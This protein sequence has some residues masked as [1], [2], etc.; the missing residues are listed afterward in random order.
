MSPANSSNTAVQESAMRAVWEQHRGGILAKVGLI[1]QAVSALGTDR[2]DDELR[3]EAQRSA[4]MLSG[5]LG[6]FGFNRASEAARELELEFAGA[7]SARTTT[8]STL[9]AIVRRGLDWE[10]SISKADAARQSAEEQIGMLVVGESPALRAGIAEL[11]VS[12]GIPC[13]TVATSSEA[14]ALCARRAPAIV[15]LDSTVRSAETEETTALLADLRLRT[16]PIPVLLLT[17]SPEFADRVQAVR[18]GSSALLPKSLDPDELLNAVEQFQAR[19]RLAA[20]RVLVV[21]DDPAVL[22]LMRALLLP[23][24]IEV[25]TLADPLRFWETLEEVTPELLILDVDMPGI[26]GAELCRT[27]RNDLRWNRL[28]VI[29]VAARSDPESVELAY[30]AG[31]DDYVAKPNL[32]PE[33]VTRIS[34]RLERV[35]M[36]RAGAEK[37]GLTGLSNR[38]T[39]EAG[40]RQLAV[41]SD[42]FSEPMSVVMLDIDLFKQINDTHG[43]ATGD[44]VLR[45][46]GGC[47]QGEFRDNDV[48]GRWGGEEFVIGMYGMTRAGAVKRLT[49]IQDRFSREEFHGADDASFHVNFSAGVA[50]YPLDAESPADIC[51][52]ADE[53]L[54]RAKADGR[55]RVA[56]AAE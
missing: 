49:E 29:F 34:S 18:G 28:M 24:G 8:L 43:H 52:A 5:S 45:R 42:R 12:R 2:F 55:A 39:T 15:L 13:E 22:A 3:A 7:T 32:G 44:R 33:F 1:E 40:L 4:H 10:P 50:E 16:P 21:D 46:F 53:A 47:L 26:N 9:L 17:D 41:L 48:V 20:T 36:F 6:M 56:A 38:V 14:R 11:S 19:R 27:V 23:H 30:S 37:D 35:R 51:Q 31:A 25:F 54:Y